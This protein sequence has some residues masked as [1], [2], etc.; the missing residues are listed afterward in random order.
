MKFKLPDFLVNYIW[1]R[2]YQGLASAPVSCQ[3]VKTIN[4]ANYAHKIAQ[5]S[6]KLHTSGAIGALGMERSGGCQNRPAV[7]AYD[8]VT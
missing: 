1:L 6:R 3:I 8:Y 4:L 2:S 5:V 7:P